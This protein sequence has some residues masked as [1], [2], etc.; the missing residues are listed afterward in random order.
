GS[1]V[2]VVLFVATML[3]RS[4]GLASMAALAMFGGL[5]LLLAAGTV[6]PEILQADYNAWWRFTGWQAN[7][8]AL[9][10]SGY[11]GVGFG[12]PYRPVASDNLEHAMRVVQAGRE[13]WTAHSQPYDL[14]YLRT[15]HNSF[16]NIFFRT[17]LV[18]GFA[19]LAFNVALLFGGYR[20]ILHGDPA[21]R[22][23]LLLAMFLFVVANSQI[24]LHVGL[25]TPRFL[26]AYAL[27]AAL[28][29]ALLYS[30]HRPRDTK[31]RV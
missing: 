24:A 22:P 13:A 21:R 12:T 5:A 11:V 1:I 2:F 9:H 10:D 19:F 14:I 15:Q 6:H 23:H 3:S 26:I 7:F 16:V 31:S 18:G 29:S 20:T 8:A 30:R 27:S 28:L 4:H 17:G 25:E